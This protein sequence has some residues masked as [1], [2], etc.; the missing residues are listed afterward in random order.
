MPCRARKHRRSRESISTASSA[1]PRDLRPGV[2]TAHTH[3]YIYLYICVRV[4][5]SESWRAGGFGSSPPTRCPCRL[6]DP[7]AVLSPASRT[8]FADAPPPASRSERPELDDAR[9]NPIL[10]CCIRSRTSCITHKHRLDEHRIAKHTR[11]DPTC[12]CSGL[13]AG[14]Q[15]YPQ[16]HRNLHSWIWSGGRLARSRATLDSW[17]SRRLQGG[18]SADLWSIASRDGSWVYSFP[19]AFFVLFEST[20]R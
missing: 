9:C 11:P 13:P 14:S 1:F 3:I 20:F 12:C 6:S 8:R 19:S 4:R 16:V 7:I 15:L 10:F 17:A 18:V 2:A 5:T